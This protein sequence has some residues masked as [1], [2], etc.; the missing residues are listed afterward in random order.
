[1]SQLPCLPSLPHLLLICRG[2]NAK[3]AVCRE[4]FRQFENDFNQLFD[5]A[6]S[7]TSAVSIA[8]YSFMTA[9]ILGTAFFSGALAISS[10]NL[11]TAGAVRF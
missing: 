10:S 11:A 7:S 3:H 4:W 6:D 9:G 8:L 5:L 2:L 1:V